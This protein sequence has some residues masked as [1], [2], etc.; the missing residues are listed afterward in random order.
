VQRSPSDGRSLGLELSASGRVLAGQVRARVAAF[1]ADI[2]A[3]VPA[4]HRAH[5]LPALRAIWYHFSS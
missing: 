3:S 4:E 1:E 5:I 2:L